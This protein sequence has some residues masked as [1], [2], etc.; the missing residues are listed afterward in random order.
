MSLLVSWWIVSKT[1]FF[2]HKVTEH[3]KEDF[4]YNPKQP[5]DGSGAL[6]CGWGQGRILNSY[7]QSGISKKK[8]A[9]EALYYSWGDIS[10]KGGQEGVNPFRTKVARKAALERDV[11]FLVARH[12]FE[13]LL[14]AYKVL[15]SFLFLCTNAKC[16][17][18]S[19]LPV[20]G[21]ILAGRKS[22]TQ[23]GV[24]FDV[25]QDKLSRPMTRRNSGPTEEHPHWSFH[26]FGTIQ[27]IIL[28]RFALLPNKT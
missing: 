9:G 28:H 18:I 24:Q 25:D 7:W 22:I 21:L 2:L 27:Q 1:V 14:S 4:K 20:Q 10:K 6:P 5:T 17:A 11:T 15:N 3:S 12:P 26:P 13:R 23:Y 19:C 8:V 16:M